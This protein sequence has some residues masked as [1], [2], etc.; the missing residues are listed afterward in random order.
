MNPCPLME[1]RHGNHL[2]RV[3]FL[4]GSKTVL[5][6]SVKADSEGSIPSPPVP[7]YLQTKSVRFV[8]GSVQV[9]VLP[10][11]LNSGDGGIIDARTIGC[12]R[13]RGTWDGYRD[14]SPRGYILKQR[15]RTG[16]SEGV[17]PSHLNNLADGCATERKGFSG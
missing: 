3:C 2:T 13:A 1:T 7:L 15:P 6:R 17:S 16:S 8:S 11:A 10:A 5:R 4:V 14:E 9:Q 12:V